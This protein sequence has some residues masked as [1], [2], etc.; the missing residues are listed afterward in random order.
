MCTIFEPRCFVVTSHIILIQ[1]NTSTCQ[2]L[3]AQ[4]NTQG[5]RFSI[6]IR[7]SSYIITSKTGN[8]N[9]TKPL[10]TH[11]WPSGPM[12]S[13]NAT[14]RKQKKKLKNWKRNR[15]EDKTK[16]ETGK[17]KF[18]SQ[19]MSFVRLFTRTTAFHLNKAPTYRRRTH[20]QGI[21]VQISSYKLKSLNEIPINML[22]IYSIFT[23]Y[24]LTYFTGS[25]SCL[26]L[27]HLSLL[28][29]LEAKEPLDRTA[30]HER[31]RRKNHLILEKHT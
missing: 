12:Q 4:I 3:S 8:S 11:Y 30:Q 9:F 1:I 25:S 10:L 23:L 18:S 15:Y 31:L 17:T 19:S 13:N 16:I 20:K 21:S 26:H 27:A 29:Q 24:S 14:K 2:H 5:S 22:Y 6:Y 7:I 28:L